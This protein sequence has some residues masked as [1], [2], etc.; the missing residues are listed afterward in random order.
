MRFYELESRADH[1]ADTV[2]ALQRMSSLLDLACRSA[3]GRGTAT[4]RIES[5][6]HAA[7]T[8]TL[9]DGTTVHYGAAD[10]AEALMPGARVKASG[11]KLGSRVLVA[12]SITAFDLKPLNPSLA[13]C[14]V[15]STVAPVQVF[16]NYQDVLYYDR[17]GYTNGGIYLLESGMGIGADFTSHCTGLYSLHVSLNYTTKA[18]VPKSKLLGVVVNS[19]LA[20]PAVLPSGVDPGKPATLTF[21]LY[22]C[23][24]DC[25]ATSLIS[26]S[27]ADA[28]ILRKGGW[29]EAIYDRRK[30]SVADGSAT[31]FDTATLEDGTEVTPDS[32]VYGVGYGIK[33]GKSTYP[34]AQFIG[35]GEQ[36]AVH[37]DVP[38]PMKP[39]G[40]LWAYIHGTRGG[41]PYHYWARLPEL[42][43][44]VV[45]FCPS[46]GVDSY[47][48]L[49]WK[50]GDTESVTQ[51]NFGSFTHSG[52]AAYALD[53]VMPVGTVGR[54]A[55]GGRVDWVREDG[56]KNW[57]AEAV[58]DPNKEPDAPANAL[59]I[60]H[61][62]GTWSWYFHMLQNGVLP[63]E[64]D[65]VER[66]QKVVVVGN[67]GYSTKPHLHFQVNNPANGTSILSRFEVAHVFDDTPVP[68]VIP[69]K[70]LWRSTNAPGT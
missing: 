37:D 29:G 11:V 49:P 22:A 16:D 63:H 1:A 10:D 58:K 38:D 34:E 7:R 26:S 27:T 48:R 53:L 65:I 46:N 14:G 21:K 43:T 66:G 61:Q 20:T 24:K 69:D 44:D 36:F 50:S 32:I 8:A 25:D 56:T 15:T 3:G 19:I 40:L 47:Y 51:G 17:R 57:F 45:S 42:V 30:F 9:S 2:A 39:T 62:D 54:A 55:R 23:W 18:G 6:D 5:I 4:G 35:E 59:R 68:C 64:G 28:Q 31:D 33:D 13:L 60:E 52:T 70:G 12:E 67:T 41:F